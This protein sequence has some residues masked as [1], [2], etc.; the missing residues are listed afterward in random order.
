M[1]KVVRPGALR[2][3]R[4]ERAVFVTSRSAER[5]RAIYMA[6][7]DNGAYVICICRRSQGRHYA[8]QIGMYMCRRG[9]VLNEPC[10]SDVSDACWE[11]PVE[12]TESACDQ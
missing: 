4:A 7:T 11:L 9:H 12:R 8:R 3:L 2:T 6:F 5:H 1:G 10:M